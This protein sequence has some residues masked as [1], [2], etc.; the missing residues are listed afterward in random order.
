MGYGV[1]TINTAY[2]RL[3]TK[4]QLTS[5]RYCKYAYLYNLYEALFV[6]FYVCACNQFSKQLIFISLFRYQ[7]FDLHICFLINE[8]KQKFK[9][10]NRVIVEQWTFKK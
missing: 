2:S 8:S 7:C 5:W 10:M 3:D 1:L 6:C 9:K 4:C